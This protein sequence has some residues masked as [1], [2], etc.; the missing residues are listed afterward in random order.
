MP[1]ALGNNTG[2]SAAYLS[3]VERGEAAMSIASRVTRSRPG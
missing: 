3:R 2:L 1:Q